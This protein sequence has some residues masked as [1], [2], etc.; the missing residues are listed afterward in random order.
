MRRTERLMRHCRPLPIF[1]RQA[2]LLLWV[3]FSR[4]SLCPE[5]NVGERYESNNTKEDRQKEVISLRQ[6]QHK[7]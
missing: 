4:L 3:H 7:R 5:I 2:H 1:L 6:L